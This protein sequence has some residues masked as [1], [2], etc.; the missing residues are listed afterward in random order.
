[1]FNQI[2]LE[3]L[4]VFRKLEWQ[5]HKNLNLIIGENDTGKTHLLKT[6]YVITRSIEEYNKRKGQF[7][8][9]SWRD[10]LANKLLWTF[11]PADW[12]LN[13]LISQGESK[14]KV[15]VNFFNQNIYFTLGKENTTTISNCSELSSEFPE[16]NALFIPA[17]EVL[18]TFDA[19]AATRE[20]LEIAGF[21]DSYYDLIKAL[22]LPMTKGQ[23][24]PDLHA[25]SF[26]L[27][28]MIE[29]QILLDQQS[30]IFKRAHEQYSMS[31]TAEG[32][33]KIGI[34]STLIRN[35]ILKQS[36]ILFIDEPETNLHPSMIITIV[37]KLFIMA[38][39]GIS[40]YLTTHSYFVLRRFEFLARKHNKSINLCSLSR[41]EKNGVIPKFYNL[42]DG[43]P[44]N[45]IIDVSLK[46]YE[47]NVLLDFEG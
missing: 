5:P 33:K 15:E 22:R 35:R 16:F 31:Q 38:S 11:Q 24:Q 21:D 45:P 25:L 2:N 6:L 20:Q 3:N 26:E 28:K 47:Q 18:T 32:I 36:T 7:N 27:D 29:G 8:S 42:Q 37:D 14:L 30:F 12:E 13:K 23:I 4:A 39:M 44:S 9:E 34:L 19:I 10:R 41:A 46:L 43:M 17:K 40:I 1:M